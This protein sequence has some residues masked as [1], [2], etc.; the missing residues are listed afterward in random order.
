MTTERDDARL[1]DL[2]TL[3]VEQRSCRRSARMMRLVLA[4]P[5][6][7]RV[8]RRIFFAATLPRLDPAFSF[9]E[10]RAQARLASSSAHRA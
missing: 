10:G 6:P 2:A 1:A 3:A 5:L 9:R 7:S 4:S 8:Q